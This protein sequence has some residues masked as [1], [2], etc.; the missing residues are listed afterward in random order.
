LYSDDTSGNRS[1]KWNKFD[2]VCIS[3]AC[4]PKKESQSLKNI[5]FIACTNN[6]SVLE[7]SKP[8]VDDFLL[9]EKGVEMFD[10]YINSNVLVIAPIIC[11]ACDNV[12]AAEMVSH[13]GSKTLKLCRICLVCIYMLCSF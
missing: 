10:A 1:K 11:M 5:H 8:V 13:L 12:R 2:V 4:L 3:L 7:I 6:L 9:L